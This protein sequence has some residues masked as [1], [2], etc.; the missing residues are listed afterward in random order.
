VD[1]VADRERLAERMQRE[2]FALAI[3]AT[4][5]EG[6]PQ[7]LHVVGERLEQALAPVEV[8]LSWRDGDLLSEVHA[9]GRVLSEEATPEDEAP[10]TMMLRVGLLAVLPGV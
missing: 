3:S 4:T 5:G 8:V 1:R 9:R 6:L 10:C 2:Q 7:L